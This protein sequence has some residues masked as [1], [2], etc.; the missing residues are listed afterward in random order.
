MNHWL[1][2]SEPGTYS[3]DNLQGDKKTTW[4]GVRNFQARSNLKAMKK[5]DLVLFYHSGEDK[6]VVGL[7]EISKEFF[8]DPQDAAWVAVELNFKKKFKKQV[9]LS[10]IKADKKLKDMVL[11]RASRLSVQP[12]RVEEF[13]YVLALTE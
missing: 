4:D 3:I 10:A 12:V 1:V 2:K 8:P 5:G 13:N 9:T 7:A 11:V 6:A